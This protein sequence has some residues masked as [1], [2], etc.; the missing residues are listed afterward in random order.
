MP[1]ARFNPPPGWPI[2]SGWKPDADWAPDP[3]WPPAPADW[4]F[5]IAET[6]DPVPAPVRDGK[7]Q[8]RILIAACIFMA[9]ALVSTVLVVIVRST[10]DRPNTRS[11]SAA[12]DQHSTSR[13]SVPTG[14]GQP[15]SIPLSGRPNTIE[16]DSASRQ[17][18]VLTTDGLTIVDPESQTVLR[19]MPVPAAYESDVAIDPATHTAWVSF[20]NRDNSPQSRTVSIIDTING[21][22]VGTVEATHSVTAVELDPQARRVFLVH[23]PDDQEVTPENRSWITTYDAD[24][25]AELS[26]VALPF[27]AYGLALDPEMRRGVAVGWMGA[28]VVTTD[29]LGVE[30]VGVRPGSSVT[31][32]AVDQYLHRAYVLSSG[33]VS[34]IDLTDGTLG[35]SWKSPADPGT[36]QVAVDPSGALVMLEWS[37]D[38]PKLLVVDPVNGRTLAS[39][40]GPIGYEQLAVNPIDGTTYVTD[41]DSQAIKVFP[42]Q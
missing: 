9:I 27:A 31:A 40:P 15:S 36:D 26:T 42:R 28:T 41:G 13:P 12:G 29:P 22:V 18:Y 5:W 25:H 3:S 2:P 20:N 19:S 34:N 16:F 21:T 35:T 23:Y 24:T 1:P 33:E 38:H 8:M 32:A 17:L 30:D 7:S 10:G 6:D 37:E 11:D 4:Q 39:A 14:L